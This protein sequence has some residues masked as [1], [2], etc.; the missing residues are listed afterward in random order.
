VQ[1]VD[2]PKLVL[3]NPVRPSKIVSLR[4]LGRIVL[5]AALAQVPEDAVDLFLC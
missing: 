2:G 1:Q 3:G 5:A 4:P